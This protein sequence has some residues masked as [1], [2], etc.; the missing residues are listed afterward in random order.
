VRIEDITEIENKEN[1]L[2]QSQ[3]ME[4][5]GNLAGGLAHDFNNVLGGI[6]GSIDLLDRTLD[7]EELQN[8]KKIIQY[9]NI[10]KHSSFRAED[11]VKQLLSL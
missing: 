5:I 4:T 3:K 9:L 10:L 7:K 6:I 1:Q 11:M 2:I 8:D